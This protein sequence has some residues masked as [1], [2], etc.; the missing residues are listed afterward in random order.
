MDE[1]SMAV[2]RKNHSR[3]SQTYPQGGTDLRQCRAYG[4]RLALSAHKSRLTQLDGASMLLS[5]TSSLSWKVVL[6]T[7]VAL[8]VPYQ[9]RMKWRVRGVPPKWRIAIAQHLMAHGV[10]LSLA[11]FDQLPTTQDKD[12][13]A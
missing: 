2:N 10:A 3:F 1:A 12:V 8:D 9:T 13:A 5:M 11:D 6:D 7:A 4:D